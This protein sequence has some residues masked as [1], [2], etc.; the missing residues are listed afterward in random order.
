MDMM[1]IQRLKRPLFII[2]HPDFRPPDR[3]RAAEHSVN[4]KTITNRIYGS[5]IILAQPPFSIFQ[6][7]TL[8]Q[9]FL[10]SL[11]PSPPIS[12]IPTLMDIQHQYKLQL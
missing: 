4:M 10:P 2:N 7:L 5:P 11:T 3:T 12:M 9:E 1:M 6:P 8:P